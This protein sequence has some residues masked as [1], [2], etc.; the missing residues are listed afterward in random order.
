MTGKQVVIDMS[1]TI[2]EKSGKDL[3]Q[4]FFRIVI[5][6]LLFGEDAIGMMPI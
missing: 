6:Y 1:E 3:E 2:K 5:M 4:W